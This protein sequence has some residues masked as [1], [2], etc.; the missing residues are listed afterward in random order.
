MTAVILDNPDKRQILSV[1]ELVTFINWKD[2]EQYLPYLLLSNLDVFQ[3]ITSN[4]V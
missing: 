4:C 2:K 1:G 3:A